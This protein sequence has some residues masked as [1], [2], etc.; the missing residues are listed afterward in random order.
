MRLTSNL[1]LPLPLTLP[2]HPPACLPGHGLLLLLQLRQVPLR[3]S[4]LHRHPSQGGAGT[5]GVGSSDTHTRVYSS[6]GG[7]ACW[8]CWV[9]LPSAGMEGLCTDA[10]FTPT[11]TPPGTRPSMASRSRPSAPPP[12]SSSARPTAASCCALTWRHVAWTSPRW[13]GSSRWVCVWGGC[14]DGVG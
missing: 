3:A 7:K 6:Q 9:L 8:A 4:V 12:S 10:G 5:C 13:T 2:P 1:P 11:P 14:W